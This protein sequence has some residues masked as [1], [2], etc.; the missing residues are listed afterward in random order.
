M[1]TLTTVRLLCEAGIET[2][3]LCPPGSR[4]HEEAQKAG[5]HVRTLPSPRIDAPVSALRV[6]RLLRER[7]YDLIHA[8]ASKDLWVLVPAL[9]LAGSTVPLLLSKHVGSFIVKR[10]F[11]HRWI[12]RRVNRAL[13]VS[14]V[15][16]KN[17]LDTTPLD[18][19]RI[20][21]LH[22]AVDIRKFDP[23]AAD[24]KIIRRKFGIRDDEIVLGITSRFSPGK[25]HEEFLR[26][27]ALLCGKLGNL[28]FLI[29]GEPSAGEN[30]YA[31]SIHRLAVE[32][33][34]NERVIFT[35]Y[36]SDIPE[37]L[38]ALDIFVF[39]SH[40]EAFGMSLVEAM[41]MEK[42]S[43]CSNCDGIVDIAID[44]VTSFLVD[45]MDHNGLAEKIAC[46]IN[47]PQLR[48]EMGRAARK[49][50]IENFSFNTFLKKLLDIYSEEI[51][52]TSRKP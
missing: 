3:L 12:Y 1:Y 48:S 47:N 2:D 5:V 23:A 45:R 30:A 43:V 11:L 32:L 6:A 46:L 52:T 25:G 50:V 16:E 49:R 42:P 17:L 9:G 51:D 4:L 35:G 26:A 41:S 22:D 8:E 40:A 36:R 33:G 18:R 37:V 20:T 13:A 28:R 34:L 29:V 14:S 10:D 38:A 7:N 21:L 27:A 39:P 15:I 31:E 44:G 24:G 19:S